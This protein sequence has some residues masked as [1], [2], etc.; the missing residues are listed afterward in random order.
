MAILRTTFTG[1]DGRSYPELELAQ[2]SDWLL[3]EQIASILE[4]ELSGTWGE[5]VDGLDERYWDLNTRSGT[6]TLHLQHYFGITIYPTSGADADPDSL[7]L[8]AHAHALLTARI[9]V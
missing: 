6:L 2:Q 1:P 8:L 3:F 7:A 5:R 9:P 4:T